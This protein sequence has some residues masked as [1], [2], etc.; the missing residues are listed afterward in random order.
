MVGA[1]VI[2]AGLVG[3]FAFPA[4]A[5]PEVEE[6]RFLTTGHQTLVAADADGSVQAQLP[7]AQK[8]PE[9]VVET[10]L[11]TTT[12]TPAP[13]NPKLN[14]NNVPKGKGAAGIVKAALAQLGQFQ[15]CTALVERSLRAV[16]YSVGDLGTL[17]SQWLQYG[18]EVAVKNAAPGDILIWE[19][20][21]VAI[22]IGNGQAVHG[23]W[24]GN[25]VVAGTTIWGS[26][27]PTS[28]VRVG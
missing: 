4:Y 11:E 25:T 18:H 19:G 24:N 16:G 28:A 21:H 9:P 1:G 13:Q 15:D 8:K 6:L 3:V 12:T 20:Q 2:S 26:Q 14:G 7:A 27:S 10:A 5:T 23:G 22:Y 17:K